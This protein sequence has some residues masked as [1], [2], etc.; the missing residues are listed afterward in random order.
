MFHRAD[1][2]AEK[3]H[4]LGPV[5]CNSSMDTIPSIP[6]LLDLMGQRCKWT[7][8]FPQM[9]PCHIMK[10]FKG[11]N[12]HLDLNLE[13]NWQ[14]VQLMENSCNMPFERHTNCSCRSPLHQLKLPNNLQGLNMTLCLAFVLKVAPFVPKLTKCLFVLHSPRKIYPCHW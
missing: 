6:L 14:S 2:M 5:G 10:G 13:A 1:P 3:A 12:Q 9:T 8:V 11:L 7:E 4:V